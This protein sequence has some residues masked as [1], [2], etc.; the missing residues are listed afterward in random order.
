MRINAIIPPADTSQYLPYR[1]EDAPT[2]GFWLVIETD[3]GE[4][5]V[6]LSPQLIKSEILPRIDIVPKG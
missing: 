1:T 3:Q 6:F 2:G 4:L 5:S